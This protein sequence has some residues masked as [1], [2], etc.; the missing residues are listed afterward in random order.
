MNKND[1]VD[2]LNLSC[3]ENYFLAWLSKYYDIS[4]L[5]GL[6]FRSAVDI[7]DDF[8]HGATYENYYKIS[9]IQDIAKDYKLINK[10]IFS[11]NAYDALS[12]IENL[13]DNSLCL[14]KV[15][16]LFF[17]KLPRSPWRDDHFIV[18]DSNLNWVNQ[19]PLSKGSFTYGDYVR[20]YDNLLLIYQINDLTISI[21]DK[22][23]K[24]IKT[25]DLKLKDIPSKLSDLESAVGIL[26]ITRKRLKE[27]YKDNILAYTV[28]TEEVDLLD[29]LYLQIRRDI[30]KGNLNKN[31][32][33]SIDSIIFFEKK[34]CEVV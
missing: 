12:I 19:Y 11:S 21:T 4:K 6:E 31:F 14:M 33:D 2:Q 18:F 22:V 28:L 5:Y 16:N 30:L 26:R 32:K 29:K 13:D 10:M 34:L 9:R 17:E 1:L 3:V 24:E 7:L 27:Y 25:Q 15:N 20:S 8:S 23:S